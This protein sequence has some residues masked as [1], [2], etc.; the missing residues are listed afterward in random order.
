LVALGVEKMVL[1]PMTAR[2]EIGRIELVRPATQENSLRAVTSFNYPIDVASYVERKGLEEG[3][4]ALR[5]IASA[6]GSSELYVVLPARYG[7]QPFR[8]RGGILSSAAQ[9]SCENPTVFEEAQ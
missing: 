8:I 2:L 4:F 9:D 5:S 3:A 7:L 1:S 6:S